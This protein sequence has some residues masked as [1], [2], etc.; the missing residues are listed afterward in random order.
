MTISVD[1]YL[2]HPGRGLENPPLISGTR[3]D[4]K[5]QLHRMLTD[6]FDRA[7]TECRIDIAFNSTAGKQDNECRDDLLAYFRKPD[8]AN[9]HKVAS[10]LQDATGNRSGIGLLFLMCGKQQ[11]YHKLVIARFPADEG[12]LAE[13]DGSKLSIAFVER[14][15]MRSAKAY[16]SVVYKT[17]TLA[18]TIWRGK[19]VDRQI[20]GPKEISQYW[21][22][23]FLM[24]GL[25]TLGATGS[26]RLATAIR[27]A[28]KSAPPELR[29]ELVAAARLVPNRDGKSGSARQ[30]L[31]RLQVSEDAIELV[32]KNMGRADLM[33][34]VFAMNADE[35]SAH[36]QY[37]SV[38]LDNGALLSAET[39]DFDAVFETQE[40]SE[41][42]IRYA[43]E[44]RVLEQRLSKEQ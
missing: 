34:D 28:V 12:V 16:K 25:T 42:R 37:R 18:G 17:P 39:A 1:S 31:K 11:G 7:D 19:A 24:S 15:F 41:G 9:G 13:Q 44:G 33:D 38:K 40:V 32:T 27:T 23:T 21:I 3:V 35:F 10:R 22:D 26:R 14:V 2:V 8:G 36:T 29:D 20:D 5:G 43:T 30:V 6:V 4:K